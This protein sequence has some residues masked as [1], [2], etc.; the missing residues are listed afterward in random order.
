M[1]Q[2]D[3]E[4]KKYLEM[5]APEHGTLSYVLYYWNKDTKRWEL[6]N[7]DHFIN[8][9]PVRKIRVFEPN[10]FV[11]EDHYLQTDENDDM[12]K[13]KLNQDEEVN[14]METAPGSGL[15]SAFWFYKLPDRAN[16]LKNGDTNTLTMNPLTTNISSI[17]SNVKQSSDEKETESNNEPANQQS[18]HRADQ[19]LITNNLYNDNTGSETVK[20]KYEFVGDENDLF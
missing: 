5:I 3:T 8:S 7:K 2:V 6:K 14:N 20:K 12:V 18:D 11:D 15:L 4:K 9:I 13:P 19:N 1:I 16:V 10:A 17:I